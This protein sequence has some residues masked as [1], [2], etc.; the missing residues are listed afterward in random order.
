[1]TRRAGMHRFIELASKSNIGGREKAAS[2]G[3]KSV[4]KFSGFEFDFLG[5]RLS[6]LIQVEI[7]FRLGID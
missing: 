7:F 5:I 1:M 3:S 4:C 2:S 6:D